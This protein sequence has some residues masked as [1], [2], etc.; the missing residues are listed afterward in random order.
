MRIIPPFAGGKR[1][2]PRVA[3][4]VV[5]VL[6]SSA[7]YF[8]GVPVGAQLTANVVAPRVTGS[9]DL[10]SPGGEAF[11]SQIP[12][13]EIPLTSS[14][15]FG[16]NTKSVLIKMA[17]NGTYLLVYASW[18]DPTQ[19]RDTDPIIEDEDFPGL[20]YANS[21]YSYEDRIVLWWSLD[22]SPGPPPCMTDAAAGKGEGRSLAGTG[23]LW[24]WKGARTDSMRTSYGKLT[25]GSGPDTGKI[26]TYAHSYA[27]NEFINAT[28]HF[29]LGYDQYPA[30]FTIGS[31]ENG[32][33]Y[34]AY[35]VSAHGV[36]NSSTHTWSWVAARNLSTSPTLD[37]IQFSPDKVYY[38][39]VAVFDGG[40]IPIPSSVARPAGWS[41]YGENAE[42]KSIS[43]WYT[44]M[45][46]SAEATTTQTNPSASL[47]GGVSFETAAIV[48]LAM[49]LVGFVAGAI[50]VARFAVPK[51]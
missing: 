34:D 19:S 1:V 17:N 20:F 24:H 2:A 5:L 21:T 33:P 35:L 38:F 31:G 45:V 9:I 28:G 47:V 48:S 3:L 22:Q 26:M 41:M 18:T 23:N 6:L 37:T 7:A 25:Y 51:K 4:L 27:D 15:D 43:S 10:N 11:W 46:R 32:V 49:L 8:Q 50:I 13:A 36:Y 42:T 40:P 14:N 16:G 44:M 12:G 30:S 29:Q 39:A